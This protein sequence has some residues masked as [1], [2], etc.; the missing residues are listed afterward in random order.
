MLPGAGW[1]WHKEPER[2]D[3]TWAQVS[4][5]AI[6]T[7]GGMLNICARPRGGYFVLFTRRWEGEVREPLY[8]PTSVQY[9]VVVTDEAGTP[10][11]VVEFASQ[12]SPGGGLFQ[13]QCEFLAPPDGSPVQLGVAALAP[14][15][16]GAYT[17]ALAERVRNMGMEPLPCPVVGEALVCDLPRVGGGRVTSSSWSESVTVLHCWATWCEPSMKE[18]E[19]LRGLR[20]EY[21]G[22][23]LVG[24]NFDRDAEAAN[25]AIEREGLDWDHVDAVGIA[26]RSAS[27][28]EMWNDAFGMR[29][30][31]R[32]IVVGRDGKVLADGVGAAE[33]ARLVEAAL[34]PRDSGGGG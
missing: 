29:G 33:V 25:G 32:V 3:L 17:R 28:L 20:K 9:R 24:I 1:K 26:G 31:P 16:R 14:E 18:L 15:G 19:T 23:R 6:A 21:P 22:L 5:I 2:L 34:A 4:P 30:L 7:P 12:S 11:D 8:G 13:T 10:L 27:R